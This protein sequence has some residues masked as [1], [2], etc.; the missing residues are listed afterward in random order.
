MVSRKRSAQAK[1][2]AAFKA[3]LG[4]MDDVFEREQQLQEKHALE[5]EEAL[6]RKACESKNRYAS[7]SEAEEVKRDCEAHG[8]R[9][10]HIYRCPYCNGWHLTSHPQD[11]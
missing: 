3:E 10:L 5:H 2:I 7:R 9:G 6:R 8:G 11:D 1:Q 4:S